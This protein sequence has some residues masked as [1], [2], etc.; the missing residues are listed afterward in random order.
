MTAHSSQLSESTQSGLNL[1]LSGLKIAERQE[2]GKKHV[3]DPLQSKRENQK[4]LVLAQ[5]GE[6]QSPL[7]RGSWDN[8]CMS[9][10]YSGLHC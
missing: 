8:G 10:G 6:G 3:E 2:G 7:H 9:Q 1:L 4:L 5:S